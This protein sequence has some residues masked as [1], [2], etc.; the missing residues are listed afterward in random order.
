MVI[1]FFAQFGEEA[2]LLGHLVGAGI[3]NA[4][5][6]LIVLNTPPKLHLDALK[7]ERMAIGVAI[8]TNPIEIMR[9]FLEVTD[10]AV[11]CIW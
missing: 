2:A 1:G 11:E 3:D 8:V 9:L 4:E 5:H 10:R 7:T 6:L